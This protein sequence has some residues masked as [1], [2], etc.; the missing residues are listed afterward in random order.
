MTYC[1]FVA[2]SDVTRRQRA[3][4]PLREREPMLEDAVVT[5]KQLG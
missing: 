3:R 4:A 5:I 2:Q 1:G